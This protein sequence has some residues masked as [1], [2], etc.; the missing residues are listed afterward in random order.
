M[1]AFRTSGFRAALL[2]QVSGADTLLV[3]DTIQ[4]VATIG[5]ATL[6]AANLTTGILY[7]S[8][9]TA[10]YTDTLDTSV[11]IYNALAGVGTD[12]QIAS[13]LAFKL[14]LINSVAFLETITLGAGMIAGTGVIASVTASTW[15]EFVFVFS[16]I[17]KPVSFIAT[18]VNG[19][20]IVTFV[21]LPG[22]VAVPIGPILGA[23]NLNPGAYVS[24]T[25]IPA[26]TTVLGVTAGQGGNT[27]F[28]MSAN[29]TASGTVIV[30]AAPLITVHGIG[31]GTL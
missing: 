22:Q 1:A 24:G 31:S 30:T 28:T 8:G 13:G 27:S 23:I 5:A 11:N 17:Q 20:A 12:P 15:R 4:P 7:R 21:L 2:E 6:T 18:T 26:N 19:S 3:P 16:N 14:R 29:A 25:G 10:G 9:S